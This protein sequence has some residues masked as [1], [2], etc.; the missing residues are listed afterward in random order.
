MSLPEMTVSLLSS[1]SVSQDGY[2]VPR[3]G[4]KWPEFGSAIAL[5]CCVRKSWVVYL[6]KS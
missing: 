6:R 1:V 2:G 4:Y 3:L 5:G